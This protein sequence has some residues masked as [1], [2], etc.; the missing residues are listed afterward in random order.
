M[1]S[2]KAM[3]FS[4]VDCGRALAAWSQSRSGK[5]KGMRVG[6]PRFKKKAGAVPSF[7]LRNKRPK[8]RPPAIRV[9]IAIVP[10]R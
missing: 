8:D 9:G 5:R 7:R 10:G 4:N 6:F 2:L 1:W 3:C